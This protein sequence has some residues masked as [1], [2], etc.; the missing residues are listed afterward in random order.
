MAASDRPGASRR[1]KG[2][3]IAHLAQALVARLGLATRVGAVLVA[4]LGCL[5]PDAH[6][7]SAFEAVAAGSPARASAQLDFRITVLPSLGLAVTPLGARVEGNSGGVTVQRGAIG[8][9]SA[10][11]QPHREVVV[12]ELVGAK[13]HAERLTVASP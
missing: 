6:A 4:A 5:L 12:R 9:N 1:P 2:K 11:L 13:G 10:Y 7:A 3:P 8:S